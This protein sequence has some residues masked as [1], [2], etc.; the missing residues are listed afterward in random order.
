MWIIISI[1]YVLGCQSLLGVF[2]CCTPLSGCLASTI[3]R[4]STTVSLAP[5]HAGHGTMHRTASYDP[6]PLHGGSTDSKPSTRR[7]EAFSYAWRSSGY[8]RRKWFPSFIPN[9]STFG[10][11]GGASGKFAGTM[12]CSANESVDM[13]DMVGVNC[14]V[15]LP[16]NGVARKNVHKCVFPWLRGTTLLH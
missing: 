12:D 16:L 11:G 8:A 5:P 3:Q 2:Q 1:S 14:D 15:G 6:S 13:V 7:R 9:G 10:Q 4:C